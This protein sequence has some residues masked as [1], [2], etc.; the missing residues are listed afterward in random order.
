MKALFRSFFLFASLAVAAHAQTVGVRFCAHDPRD[1]VKAF[2]ADLA[3]FQFD[4]NSDKTNGNS[5]SWTDDLNQ[6]DLS[7]RHSTAKAI[8]A[9]STSV[10]LYQ[11]QVNNAQTA[12]LIGLPSG[13]VQ[14]PDQQTGAGT[15]LS[16]TTSLVNKAGSATLLS[17]ALDGGALTR[18][19]NGA[20][21]TVTTNADQ[22]FR[23]ITRSQPDCLVNSISDYWIERKILNL[24]NISA[25]FALSQQSSTAVPTSGQASGTTPTPVDSVSVFSGAGKLSGLTV[26][27]QVLNKFDPRSTAFRK[28]WNDE[29][30]K[31]TT[32]TDALKAVA[33]AV[34]PL[35]ASLTATAK[36]IDRQAIYVAASSDS[37]GKALA[38]YFSAYF[39]AAVSNSLADPS[40]RGSVVKIAQL[41][42]IYQ[43][44]WS[45]AVANAAG[46]L[47]SLQYSFNKPA[48]QPETHD[49]TVIFGYNFKTMGMLTFNGAVS[50]YGTVP[51][52][53]AYG[54]VHYGQFSG[55]YDQKAFDSGSLQGQLSLAGYWQYQPQPSVLNI[56][57]GTV[58]PGQAFLYRVGPRSLLG[59]QVLCGLH[60][61]K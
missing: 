57:A 38:D 40:F 50:L 3:Q 13:V 55:E 30:K 5:S 2:C 46:T 22:L 54:R 43:L 11:A 21:T 4:V 53:A 27:F 59:R 36:P 34:N 58:A 19:V 25:S 44:A 39:E 45:A 56:A 35:V 28:T 1:E 9:V 48:S 14:T 33:D 61:R 10:A 29:I 47:L 26:K 17:I 16:G 37:S 18:S 20:T 52:G 41:R 6:L 49:A 42:A 15:N 8:T 7:N 51:A 32:L 31:N 60:R 23:A 12:S 24:T